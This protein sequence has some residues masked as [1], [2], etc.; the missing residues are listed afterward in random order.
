[1]DAKDALEHEGDIGA[2]IHVS[3]SVSFQGF[4]SFDKA[5]RAIA[6]VPQ[7][8]L[9]TKPLPLQSVCSYE[10]VIGLLHP[11]SEQYRCCWL[12]ENVQPLLPFR[13]RSFAIEEWPGDFMRPAAYLF[14]EVL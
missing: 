6:Y 2:K 9:L 4:L 14:Q 10:T 12:R 7:R 11:P 13:M 3:Y 1:M 8:L 5:M